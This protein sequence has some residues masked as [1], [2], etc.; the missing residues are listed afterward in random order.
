[1]AQQPQASW[2][3]I[4]AYG[5]PL[6][7]EELNEITNTVQTDIYAVLR[8]TTLFGLDEEQN[9]IYGHFLPGIGISFLTFDK[10]NEAAPLNY[11]GNTVENGGS[12]NTYYGY[13]SDFGYEEDPS[14]IM[15]IEAQ[16]TIALKKPPEILYK[17]I[18]NAINKVM[19]DT[20]PTGEFIRD[21]INTDPNSI[22]YQLKSSYISAQSS[23][24]MDY[25]K[26]IEKYQRSE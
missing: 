10:N 13:A 12:P 16:P 18:Q 17:E 8:G 24:N 1:M 5:M 9:L 6:D 3:H 2:L 25:Y 26:D 14:Y 19:K 20:T 15:V 23:A 22:H 7:T 11:M 21:I 4:N